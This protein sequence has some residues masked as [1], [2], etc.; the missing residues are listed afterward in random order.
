MI[1]TI[2][3]YSFNVEA[4]VIAAKNQARNAHGLPVDQNSVT[5]EWI[6][7]NISYTE[8]DEEDFYYVIW[9][10]SLNPLFG[11]PEQIEINN[12]LDGL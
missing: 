12:G 4:A 3:G 7:Y 2:T 5:Q 11:Q 10:D 6:D 1:F 8:Q 9:D